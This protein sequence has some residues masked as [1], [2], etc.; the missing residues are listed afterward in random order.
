MSQIDMFTRR[1]RGEKTSA[2]EI[3]IHCML[4]DTLR[5]NI[6]SDWLW[7]HP[8]NGGWRTKAEAGKFVRMGVKAGVSDLI[9]AAP[10]HAMLHALEV[11]KPGMKPDEKQIAF[12]EFVRLIGGKAE[13]VDNYGDGVRILNEWGALRTKVTVV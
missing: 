9:L 1:A 6:R 12:M 7:F 10:P 11:K 8:A 2:A 4:A 3:A 5:I 13:W